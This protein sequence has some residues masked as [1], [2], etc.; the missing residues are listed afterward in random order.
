LEGVIGFLE[1]GLEGIV[2]I[3]GQFGFFGFFGF[4]WFGF[5]QGAGDFF[6]I[7]GAK[8]NSGVDGGF[9]PVG[10]GF[11]E[12]VSDDLNQV[13]GDSAAF[14]DL[15]AEDAIG[16]VGAEILLHEKVFSFVKEFVGFVTNFVVLGVVNGVFDIFDVRPGA[17]FFFGV[18]DSF[19]FDVGGGT[20]FFLGGSDFHDLP[21]FGSVADLEGLLGAEPLAEEVVEGGMVFDDMELSDSDSGIEIEGGLDQVE[22]GVGDLECGHGRLVGWWLVGEQACEFPVG[23][24]GQPERCAFFRGEGFHGKVFVGEF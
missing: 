2:G 6:A 4:F 14:V 9:G 1:V 24:A 17:N 13:K 16:G 21:A 20:A 19:G 10:V 11:P 15:A 18:P 23:A 8:P 3:F 12:L 5:V 7:L 22:L